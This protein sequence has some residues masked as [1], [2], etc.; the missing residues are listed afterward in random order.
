MIEQLEG[1]N[2]RQDVYDM[3]VI[4]KTKAGNCDI[5]YHCQSLS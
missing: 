4:G 1:C 3:I 5:S 2:L